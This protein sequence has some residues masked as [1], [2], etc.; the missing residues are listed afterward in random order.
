MFRRFGDEKPDIEYPCAWSYRL[1]ARSAE[2]IEA[3]V[4]RVVGSSD[5]RLDASNTSATGRY[6]AVRLTVVVR[7]EEHRLEIGRRLK[8]DDAILYVL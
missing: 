7:D 8:A 5:Y 3:A 4:R 2:V 1:I 6:V